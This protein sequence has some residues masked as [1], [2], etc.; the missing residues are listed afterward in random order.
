MTGLGGHLLQA[1][2]FEALA[3][4]DQTEL[5]WYEKCIIY[6]NIYKGFPDTGLCF[7]FHKADAAAWKMKLVMA[8]NP[9]TKSNPTPEQTGKQTAKIWSSSLKIHSLLNGKDYF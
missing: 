2:H 9:T 5:T 8:K 6:S 4:R 1:P 7:P 3:G